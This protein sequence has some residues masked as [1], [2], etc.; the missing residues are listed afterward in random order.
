MTQIESDRP[1]RS[2]AHDPNFRR[3]WA[4]DA[5]GQFAAQVSGFLIPVLAVSRLEATPFQMGALSSAQTA[6]VLAIG[7]PA[8]AWIDRMRKRPTLVV[9][10]VVRAVLLFVV[11]STA[12]TGHASIGLLLVIGAALSC[13]SVFFDVAHQSYVPALVGLDRV[14]EGNA[15]LQ[16]LQSAAVVAAPSL[17]GLLVPLVGLP[18]ALGLTTVS[19]LV[20]ATLVSRIV[21]V[22]QLPSVEARRPLRQEI[23]EGLR[24]V[25]THPLLARIVACTS[26][27]NFF[28]AM[29]STLTVIYALRSLTI[30]E[31]SLGVLFA[32]SGVGG[33]LG[34]GVAARVI[35]RLGEGRTIVVAA[36]VAVPALALMPLAQPLV[37]VGVPPALVVGASFLVMSFS[38]VVYNVAQV[39]MRQQVCPPDLLGRMN[40]SVRFMVWGVLPLGALVGGGLGGMIGLAPTLWI[41]VAGTAAAV[42]PVLLSPLRSGPRVT[43]PSDAVVGGPEGL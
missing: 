4:G 38:G 8:G 33:L 39:S 26:I 29:A 15:K 10:D 22:E 19:Y 43:A 40:A 41:G 16:A 42:V 37:E 36:I 2:L 17:G 30:S 18:V 24:F 23:A 1:R 28:G 13:A 12:A 27:G 3:L 6:A 5:F 32:V 31:A 11:V 14:S 25:I 20:S 21:H 9:A 7:L 35:K 34:A